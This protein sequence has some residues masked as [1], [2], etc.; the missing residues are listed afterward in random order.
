MSLNSYFSYMHI[1]LLR[2]LRL[3]RLSI[4]IFRRVRFYVLTAFFAMWFYSFYYNCVPLASLSE[5]LQTV[6]I[7]WIILCLSH[8]SFMILTRIMIIIVHCHFLDIANLV[9]MCDLTDFYDLTD[10]SFISKWLPP[11]KTKRKMLKNIYCI[12]VSCG[13]Y[14]LFWRPTTAQHP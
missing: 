10:L 8:H 7:I 12:V 9:I 6:I 4:T 13:S 5:Y 2:R 11:P 3:F 1:Y 14:C